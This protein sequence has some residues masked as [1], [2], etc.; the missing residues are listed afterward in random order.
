MK[1]KIIVSGP[2]LSSS[3]YG[4]MCRFAIESLLTKEDVDLYLLCTNWGATGNIL[5]D[6]K[7]EEIHSFYHLKYS[8]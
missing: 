6:K 1:K 5:D 3:G 2:A 7:I 4:R 8:M